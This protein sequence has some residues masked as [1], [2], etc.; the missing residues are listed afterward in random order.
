LISVGFNKDEIIELEPLQ[1]VLVGM[2]AGCEHK[3]FH[4]YNDYAYK[5]GFSVRYSRTCNRC[6]SKGEGY[7]CVNF[8]VRKRDSSK[9]K[10]KNIKITRMLML[11]QVARHLFS[12]T[13]M[14]M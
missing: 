12:F 10:V 3:A 4:I 7:V 14:K 13:L 5:V 8:V 11:G 6:K 9:T 2:R 1:E